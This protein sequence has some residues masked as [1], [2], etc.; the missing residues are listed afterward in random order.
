MIVSLQGEIEILRFIDWEEVEEE[1]TLM[2]ISGGRIDSQEERLV[3]VAT[4][5]LG[6][7]TTIML[8]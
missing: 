8:W 2:L 6:V 3:R 4:R 5:Q 7:S 1:E